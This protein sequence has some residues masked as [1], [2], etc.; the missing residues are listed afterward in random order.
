MVRIKAS[1]IALI[2]KER[3]K[4]ATIHFRDEDFK[5]NIFQRWNLKM[6]IL[7]EF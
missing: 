5:N 6:A 4:G 3:E 1:D 7:K 2:L